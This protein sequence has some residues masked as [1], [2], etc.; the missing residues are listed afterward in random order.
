MVM[1]AFQLLGI[2]APSS[3]LFGVLVLKWGAVASD[4]PCGRPCNR[5]GAVL[6]CRFLAAAFGWRNCLSKAAL[7]LARKLRR[8]GAN[9]HSSGQP[10]DLHHSTW[11]TRTPSEQMIARGGFE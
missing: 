7:L 8:L 4:G 3:Y 1:A 6:M 2:C 5:V 9:A 10:S 11:R